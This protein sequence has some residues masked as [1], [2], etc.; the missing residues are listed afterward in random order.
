LTAVQKS[1]GVFSQQVSI[2]QAFKITALL[3]L[4]IAALSITAVAVESKDPPAV[5]DGGS[6]LKTT[7]QG[8]VVGTVA[9]VGHASLEVTSTS[10]K[11]AKYIPQWM[12]A[13]HGPEKAIVKIL[14]GLKV[15]DKVAVQ[16]YVNDHLRIKSVEVLK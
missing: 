3:L 11:T 12:M 13:D 7:D 2:M 16:W 1:A 5:T 15:G 9:S 8:T 14:A 6:E 4:S 10:G